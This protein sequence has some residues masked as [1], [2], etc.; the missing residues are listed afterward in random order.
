MS[1]HSHSHLHSPKHI[2]SDDDTGGV[3]QK[4]LLS[5]ALN[6]AITAIQVVG[7]LV[8][9]S[10]SLIGD[11]MHN[12]ADTFSLVMS[13]FAIKV[14]GKKRRRGRPLVMNEWRYWL[15]F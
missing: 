5:I 10:L 7:G 6:F 4:L 14:S 1:A 12:L 15:P 13:Y 9:G 3:E 8:T 2:H 11:A